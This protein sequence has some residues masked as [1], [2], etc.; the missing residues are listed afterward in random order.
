MRKSKKILIGAVSLIVL[1]VIIWFAYY[2]MNY[3]YFRL[4]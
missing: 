2:L 4:K 1:G 3:V